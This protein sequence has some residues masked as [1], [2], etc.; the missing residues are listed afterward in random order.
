MVSYNFRIVH[1][2]SLKNAVGVL[3]LLDTIGSGTKSVDLWVAPHR[4]FLMKYF[5]LTNIFKLSLSSVYL[6]I[7]RECE[8]CL[9]V[10]S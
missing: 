2:S 10:S 9:D 4:P 8:N 7:A 1:S 6:K 3:L 5:N